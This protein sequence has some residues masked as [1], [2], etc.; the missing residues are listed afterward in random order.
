M[1]TKDKELI[2]N[3]QAE[4]IGEKAGVSVDKPA[5]EKETLKANNDEFAPDMQAKESKH[6]TNPAHQT[7]GR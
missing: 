5:P 4:R 3:S 6:Q 2:N 1:S 7:G